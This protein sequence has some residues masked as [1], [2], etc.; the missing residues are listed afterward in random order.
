MRNDFFGGDTLVI[1]GLIC[2]VDLRPGTGGPPRSILVVL[3]EVM[4]NF[5]KI[6]LDGMSLADLTAQLEA[7]GASNHVNSWSHKHC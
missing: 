1:T 7:R 4:F 2:A 5:D 6:T 3:P